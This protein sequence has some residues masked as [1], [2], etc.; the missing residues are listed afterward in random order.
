MLNWSW[1]RSPNRGREAPEN[2]GWSSISGANWGA[3]G[4]SPPQD[5]QNFF[6]YL[7]HRFNVQYMYKHVKLYYISVHELLSIGGADTELLARQRKKKFLPRQKKFCPPKKF[8]N[9]RPWPAR[10]EIRWLHGDLLFFE[11]TLYLYYA[12]DMTPCIPLSADL[13]GIS[14]W[15]NCL[16]WR[17]ISSWQFPRRPKSAINKQLTFTFH[18]P[19]PIDC[20]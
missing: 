17:F 9:W 7:F 10:C 14:N 18:K 1:G 12:P 4:P 19:C 5:S 2:R 13:L 16:D 15:K 6:F 20:H 11:S 3:G 8:V